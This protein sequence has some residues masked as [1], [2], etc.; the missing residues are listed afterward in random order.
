[1]IEYVMLLY[2]IFICIVA[3]VTDWKYGK[4]YNK[5]LVAGVCPGII[6][7]IFYYLNHQES[8]YLFL[9]NLS[10]ALVIAVLFF[11]LK[12]WG[13]GDSKLWLFVNFLYPAGWYLVSDQML[14]PLM[15]LL[16]IIFI[17][18]YF[19]LLCESV[20]LAVFHKD[21]AVLFQKEKFQIDQ[22]WDIIFSI[23]CLSIVYT[24]CSYILN[25]YYE[26]NRIESV[27]NSV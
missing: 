24:I 19:Y 6:L 9:T 1:M 12:M 27:I 21:R 20:W 3:A 11:A 18:A 25:G 23:S 8:I 7:V 22:I 14:F 13:A 15:F 10:S 4:I 26:N 5:W 2:L 16:M 17:E